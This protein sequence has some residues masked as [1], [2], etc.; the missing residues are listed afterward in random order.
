MIYGVAADKSRR[1]RAI[2]LPRARER[3]TSFFIDSKA[4]SVAYKLADVLA[5]KLTDVD[6]PICYY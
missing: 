3:W 2:G 1:T 5:Y 4:L 6:Y